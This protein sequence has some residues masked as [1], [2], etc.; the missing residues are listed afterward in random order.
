[1]VT[2]QWWNSLP[3]HGTVRSPRRID[4]T[5]VQGTFSSIIL[6]EHFGKVW[7]TFL[8]LDRQ[9]YPQTKQDISPS[10]F[11]ETTSHTSVHSYQLDCN[12]GKIGYYVIKICI[13]YEQSKQCVC[14]CVRITR[15]YWT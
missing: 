4:K 11:N 3:Y 14:V 15:I 7:Y 13:K 9:K 12:I 8:P 5:G 10:K 6:G 2:G 1:M